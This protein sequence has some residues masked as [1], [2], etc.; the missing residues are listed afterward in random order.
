MLKKILIGIA[1]VIAVL[2]IGFILA[3]VI[4]PVYNGNLSVTVN[5]PASKTF[6]VFNNPD[7]M[8][9]WMNHFKSIK[10]ISGGKNEVG[11]KWQITF[12]ENGRDLVMNETVTAFEQDKH[13]AFDMEDE[14][15]SFHIDITFD[16]INGQ[17]VISQTST[18]AGKG[19]M[20][21]S[22]IALMSSAIAKQQVEMYNRLKALVENS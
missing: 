18:G 15:A 22:M 2:I 17:T 5:A 16:E 12:D 6:E 8:G 19:I 4:K 1:A 11:S 7:N 10:N 20:S 9:K 21:R 14:F 3:G 13:F